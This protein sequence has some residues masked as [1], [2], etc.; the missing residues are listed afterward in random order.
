MSNANLPPDDL[1]LVIKTT[2]M[3]KV[4]QDVDALLEEAYSVIGKRPMTNAYADEIEHPFAM[5]PS[6]PAK[7]SEA[8]A[9]QGMEAGLM[10]LQLDSASFGKPDATVQ[11]D[12]YE[13]AGSEVDENGNIKSKK[14]TT[15]AKG[16][17]LVLAFSIHNFIRLFKEIIKIEF[18]I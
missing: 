15:K 7:L 4:F 2:S 17:S 12:S 11:S 10:K 1:P 8:D 18:E 14:K 9:V 5:I 3:Y 13:T 16:L 6:K